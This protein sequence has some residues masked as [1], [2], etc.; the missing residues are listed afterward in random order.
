MLDTAALFGEIARLRA[1]PL[2]SLSDAE[3]EQLQRELTL[4]ARQLQAVQLG[5]VAEID[6]RG[7]AGGH[8]CASTAAYLVQVNRIDAGEA[9]GL[10][11][12]AQRL[13]PRRALTGEAL[14]P[15]FPMLAEGYASGVV[16][17]RQARVITS[18]IEG[19]PSAV[20]A[21][22]RADCERFLAEQ[23]RVFEPRTLRQLARRISDHLDP[24]GTL[25]EAA[26][27][28]RQRGL[29]VQQRPDGSARVDG[30]LTALCAEALLTCLDSLAKPRPAEDRGA[31]TRNA[32]QRR[33]DALHDTL[34]AA[35]RSGQLPNTGGVAATIQVT[36]TKE[37]AETGTGLARTGHGA[38][39]PVRTALA[40]AGDAQL[41]VVVTT[42]VGAVSAYSSTQRLFTAAQRLAMAARDLGCS[43]PGCTVPAAWCEAHHVI[44]DSKGGPTSIDNGALLCG[45]HHR[46]FES[47]GFSCVMIDGIPHW[48]AP[49]WLDPTRTPRRNYAHGPPT[50]T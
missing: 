20:D 21:D 43:L 7:L 27:R 2:A 6:Q 16:S 48:I 32:S 38:F 25:I 23:A 29:T 41:Q 34:R 30:E 42:K 33:H 45:D 8:G 40:L 46:N 18:C 49:P 36:M 3:V 10:V 35:L 37:Q 28:E 17:L 9:T 26:Q 15:E 11:R 19:L 47:R 14:A 22:T 1:V 4:A 31:D 5:T 12:T 50:G 13:M 24:D 44:E 39:I